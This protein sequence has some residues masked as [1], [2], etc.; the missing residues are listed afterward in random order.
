MLLKQTL[1]RELLALTLSLCGELMGGQGSITT[2]D[3]MNLH[4]SSPAV[5]FT[6]K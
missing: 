3:N 1:L 2:A 6:H 5:K 4:C